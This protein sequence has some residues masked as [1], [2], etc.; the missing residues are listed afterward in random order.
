MIDMMFILLIFI[1]V[2]AQFTK[3]HHFLHLQLP[4]TQ[5]G[6]KQKNHTITIIIERD[7]NLILNGSR[8][9]FPDLQKKVTKRLFQNR[10]VTILSAADAPF[11]VFARLISYLKEGNC[12]NIQ[13]GTDIKK[14]ELGK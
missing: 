14:Y 2:S 11:G 8:L 12:K 10:G 4:R 9:T 1:M 7:G 3:K 13:I 6:E 5:F